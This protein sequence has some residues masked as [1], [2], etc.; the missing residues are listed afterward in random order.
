VTYKWRSDGSDADLLP[1]GLTEEVSDGSRKRLWSYPSRNDCLLCHT[2][3]AGFVLGVKTRQLNSDHTYPPTGVRANQLQMWNQLGM[4]ARPFD[5][6]AIS[7][8]ARL[9]PLSDAAAP[10][11]HRVRSY[12]DANCA[13]C[14]RPGGARAAFDARFDTPLSQ[15]NLVNGSLLGADLGV[16]GAKAIVPGSLEHSMLYL[17]MNRRR[18][19]FNMPPL[20]SHEVDEEAMRVLREWIKSL[21]RR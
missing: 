18:D 17:R 14:H 3:Q 15:Q 11:E 10:L 4:F 16:A 13:H 19:V 21:P 1:G 8:F 7:G 2:T 12:L 6:A 9:V 20:A 5:E